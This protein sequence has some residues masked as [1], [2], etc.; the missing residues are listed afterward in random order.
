MPKKILLACAAGMSTSILVA[1]M[2]KVAAAKGKD[3][4]IWATAVDSIPDEED[5]FDVV[6]VG[7]QMAKRIDEI[8]EF[9]EEFSGHRNG[10]PVEIIPKENYGKVNGEAVLEQ[11]E[12]LLEK[13]K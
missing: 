10:V 11:A 3:Y 12:R 9:G 7:P 5:G 6:L 2:K 13:V 8:I 1:N 4:L